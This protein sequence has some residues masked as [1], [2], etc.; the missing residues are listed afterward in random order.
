MSEDMLERMSEDMSVNVRKHVKRY[1]RKIVIG[2]NL[3]ECQKISEK[4]QTERQK[5]CQA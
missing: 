1:V 5:E 3:K 4:C 2:N